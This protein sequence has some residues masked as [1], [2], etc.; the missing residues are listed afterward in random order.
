[1]KEPFVPKRNLYTEAKAPY[2]FGKPAEFTEIYDSPSF[3]Y[4]I[5]NNFIVIPDHCRAQWDENPRSGRTAEHFICCTV[6]CV[7]MTK[8]KKTL[9]EYKAAYETEMLSQ[10][11]WSQ[12]EYD[13]LCYEI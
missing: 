1:M 8:K 4:I 13:E 7:Y 3:N 12:N 6:L 11:F 10:L 9:L 5:H 2:H